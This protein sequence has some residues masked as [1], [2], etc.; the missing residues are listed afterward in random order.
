[1]PYRVKSEIVKYSIQVGGTLYVIQSDKKHC[2]EEKH[3][4]F[5]SLILVSVIRIILGDDYMC[6]T[7]TDM[8]QIA[9]SALLDNE[10]Q[11]GVPHG[12]YSSIYYFMLCII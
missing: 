7:C 9:R 5:F 2:Q 4:T 12:I 1:M 3:N 8:I 11:V 6:T 10:T